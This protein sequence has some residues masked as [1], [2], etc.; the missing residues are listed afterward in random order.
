[1]L[2]AITSSHPSNVSPCM[3]A[4]YVLH[5]YILPNQYISGSQCLLFSK[6]KQFRA[7]QLKTAHLKKQRII[8]SS[9]HHPSGWGSVAQKVLEKWCSALSISNGRSKLLLLVCIVNKLFTCQGWLRNLT[10]LLRYEKK[11]KIIHLR[12]HLPYHLVMPPLQIANGWIYIN[13]L[14]LCLAVRFCGASGW[15]PAHCQRAAGSQR[16]WDQS[17]DGAPGCCPPG[18]IHPVPGLR[19]VAPGL[20]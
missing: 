6:H 15:Q 17:T 11:G 1:M 12:L 8:I 7:R 4:Y 19:G 18:R 14:G 10:L 2:K 13:F 5:S 20:L 9:G 16:A 3:P